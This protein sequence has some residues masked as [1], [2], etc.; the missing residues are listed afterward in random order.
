[1]T[2]QVIGALCI[3]IALIGGGLKV[4]EIEIPRLS[5]GRMIALTIAGAAFIG[6]GFL[7]NEA[8]SVGA[9][10]APEPVA[11]ATTESSPGGTA[12]ARGVGDG[13]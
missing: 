3:L 4:S 2:L 12:G 13:G 7:A 5:E 6:L 1:M 9:P 10:S 8:S 11:P